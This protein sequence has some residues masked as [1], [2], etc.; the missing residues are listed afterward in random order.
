[1]KKLISGTFDRSR[2]VRYT[3]SFV[4][5]SQLENVL[6]S[7]AMDAFSST[8]RTAGANLVALK[9]P[10]DV[11]D[12]SMLVKESEEPWFLSHRTCHLTLSRFTRQA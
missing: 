5:D 1:M 3:L 10:R 9:P 6:I 12:K 4:S 11:S 7:W 2:F 8:L